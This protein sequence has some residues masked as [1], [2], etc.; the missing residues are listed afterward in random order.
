M[1]TSGC[2]PALATSA[3]KAIGSLSILTVETNSPCSSRCTITDRR[4]CK[5]IPTYCR[6]IGVFL[7]C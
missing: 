2:S 7:R 1:T 5:S 6:S 3:A 4:R